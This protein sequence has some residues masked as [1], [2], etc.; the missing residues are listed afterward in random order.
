LF[1]PFSQV[2]GVEI[3]DAGPSGIAHWRFCARERNSP[4]LLISST[5]VCIQICLVARGEN[6]A[7]R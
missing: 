7:F 2:E 1:A 4:L 6:L 3:I 5:R